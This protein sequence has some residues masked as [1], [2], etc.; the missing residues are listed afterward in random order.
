MPHDFVA[1]I[2]QD[3][4]FTIVDLQVDPDTDE[5]TFVIVHDL[6]PED[7]V[8]VKLISNE[9]D[10]KDSMLLDFSGPDSYTEDE[11]REVLQEVSNVLVLIIEEAVNKLENSGSGSGSDSGSA[12]SS[13]EDE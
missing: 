12:S 7:E 10:G 3:Q 9:E 1:E 4:K 13:S 5:T 8:Q 11:A 2:M 6:H